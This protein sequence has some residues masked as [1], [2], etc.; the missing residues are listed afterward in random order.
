MSMK[1]QS[2]PSNVV[3]GHILPQPQPIGN[4]QQGGNFATRMLQPSEAR[5]PGPLPSVERLP[6]PPQPQARPQQINNNPFE[7]TMNTNPFVE[8]D[9]NPFEKKKSH[10]PFEEED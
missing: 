6:A 3:S 4:G 10:N 2:T 9:T 8:M 5:L 7:E 1:K